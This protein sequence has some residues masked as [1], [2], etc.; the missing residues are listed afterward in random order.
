MLRCFNR[1]YIKNSL[2]FL[3]LIKHLD[4]AENGDVYATGLNDFGQL[5]IAGKQ[6]YSTVCFLILN[7]CH[8]AV[9]LFHHFDSPTQCNFL[10]C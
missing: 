3:M 5:G 8:V 4:S 7:F 10:S 1:S 6:D 9:E 2:Y